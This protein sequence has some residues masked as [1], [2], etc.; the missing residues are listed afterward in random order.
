MKGGPP[1]HIPPVSTWQTLAFPHG[2]NEA[3]LTQLLNSH[4]LVC[5]IKDVSEALGT[6]HVGWVTAAARL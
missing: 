4:F 6:G 2:S 1:H 3:E 5:T